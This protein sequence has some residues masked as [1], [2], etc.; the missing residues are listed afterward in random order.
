VETSIVDFASTHVSLIALWL[1]LDLLII[2]IEIFLSVWLLRIFNTWNKK[3]SLSAFLLRISMVVI[4]LVNAVFLLI[5]LID[6]GVSADTYVAYHLTGVYAWQL[7]FGPH[8]FLLGFMVFKYIKTGWKYLGLV[9]MVGALG[10]F[11][12]ALNYLLNI[13]SSLLTSLVSFLLIFVTLGELGMSL[14]L[15][16]RKIIPQED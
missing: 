11:L 16:L 9:G 3:L 7:L 4:M 12:D 6:K 10:Y 15:I 1:L 14:A 13:D 2:V 8:I 5:M